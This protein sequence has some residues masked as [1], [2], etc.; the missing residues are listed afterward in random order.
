MLQQI[1]M[2]STNAHQMLQFR[3]YPFTFPL[4][5]N[6]LIAVHVEINGSSKTLRLNRPINLVLQQRHQ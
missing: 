3:L 6:G 5:A 4:F 1:E 2:D